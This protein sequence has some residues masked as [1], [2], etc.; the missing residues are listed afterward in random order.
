M[1]EN[2]MEKVLAEQIPEAPLSTENTQVIEEQP[3][4]KTESMIGKKIN[5]GSMMKRIDDSEFDTQ[6]VNKIFEIYFAYTMKS[7]D[8]MFFLVNQ[9]K[10]HHNLILA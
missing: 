3:K 10:S 8:I 6:I 2:E 4:P 9:Q 1:N 5:V 7:F